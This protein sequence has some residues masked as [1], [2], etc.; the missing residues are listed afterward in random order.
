[1]EAKG[2]L[3]ELVGVLAVAMATELE[4]RSR[5]SQL[6]RGVGRPINHMIRSLGPE[7]VELFLRYRGAGGRHSVLVSINGKL[8]Q[9]EAG[10]LFEF[11]CIV[12]DVFNQVLVEELRLR[13][14][15]PARVIRFGRAARRRTS[16][17]SRVVQQKLS[18]PYFRGLENMAIC[19]KR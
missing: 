6:G 14:L 16:S 15:S 11:A 7:S 8:A 2:I 18:R 13:P 1:M 3:S 10:P 9:K 19:A 12:L 4:A 5:E 17:R